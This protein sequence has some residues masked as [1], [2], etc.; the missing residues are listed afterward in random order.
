MNRRLPSLTIGLFLLLPASLNHAGTVKPESPTR[1]PQGLGQAGH[2][3]HERNSFPSNG[4]G[5]NC[6]NEICPPPIF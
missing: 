4:Y 1:S 2:A 3:L 6:G 5:C